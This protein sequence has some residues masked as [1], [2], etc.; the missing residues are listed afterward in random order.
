MTPVPRHRPS[1]RQSPHCCR[2]KS[3][4][5]EDCSPSEHWVVF[6][7]IGTLAVRAA[8]GVPAAVPVCPPTGYDTDDWV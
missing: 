2:W 6:G 4:A 7:L 8:V 1:P 5:R 3:A